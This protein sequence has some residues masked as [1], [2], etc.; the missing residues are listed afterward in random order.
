LVKKVLRDMF[1]VRTGEE[2]NELGKV[3]EWIIGMWQLEGAG[4]RAFEVE[5]VYRVFRLVSCPF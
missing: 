5:P 4:N 2:R 1:C 3:I